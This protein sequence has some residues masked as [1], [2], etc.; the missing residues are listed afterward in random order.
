[1]KRGAKGFR[2]GE[3]RE[4][5]RGGGNMYQISTAPRWNWERGGGGKGSFKEKG[6]VF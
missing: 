1:M 2:E 5:E 4:K 3:E 6:N